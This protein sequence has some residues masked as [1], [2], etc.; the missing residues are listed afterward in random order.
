METSKAKEVY[1]KRKIV[2]Q[3]SGNIEIHRI[4]SSWVKQN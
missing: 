3:P 2:E 4:H 1:R